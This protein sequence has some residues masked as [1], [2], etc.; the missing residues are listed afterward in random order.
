MFKFKIFLILLIL[1]VSYLVYHL[2]GFDRGL[3]AYYERV[4]LLKKKE[5]YK[6]DLLYQIGEFTDKLKLLDEDSLDL[7]YLEEKSFEILGNNAKNSYIII[8]K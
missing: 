1:P 2:V 4:K 3:N 7:D 6:E 5:K 8:L